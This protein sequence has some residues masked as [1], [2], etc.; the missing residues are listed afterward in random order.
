[1]VVYGIISHLPLAWHFQFLVFP[2]AVPAGMLDFHMALCLEY[3]YL[4]HVV[5]FS[6]NPSKIHKLNR[7]LF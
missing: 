5:T 6:L 7:Y 3:V 2:S 1:M 4:M